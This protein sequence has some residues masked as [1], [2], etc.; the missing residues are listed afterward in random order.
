MS[1]VPAVRLTASVR[2]VLVALAQRA[3]VKV[4]VRAVARETGLSPATVRA[5]LSALGKAGLVRHTLQ[6]QAKDQPPH[7]VY[8]VT[9]AGR[10]IAA[11]QPA[12]DPPA[13]SPRRA[14]TRAGAGGTLQGRGDA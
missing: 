14:R 9:Q 4:S 7:L 12:P 3:G 10:D 13:R 1:D 5:A 2:R 11:A 6:A 8:W